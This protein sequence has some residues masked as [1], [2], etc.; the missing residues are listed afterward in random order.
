MLFLTV[1]QTG[2][3]HCLGYLSYSHSLVP[4]WKHAAGIR[5]SPKSTWYHK[6][7]L[8]LDEELGYTGRKPHLQ[9]KGTERCPLLPGRG[10]CSHWGTQTLTSCTER[11]LCITQYPTKITV[12][13]TQ[14]LPRRRVQLADPARRAGGIFPAMRNFSPCPKNR[15]QRC[16]SG[17]W[18]KH[19]VRRS[20]I[21]LVTKCLQG[22]FICEVLQN[23]RTGEGG[24]PHPVQ[25]PSSSRVI[26]QHILQDCIQAVLEYLHIFNS[27][28][29]LWRKCLADQT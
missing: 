20:A 13:S 5:I 26:L 6:V 18:D 3:S 2:I 9:N 21:S 27:N 11:S 25:P 7:P 8:S 29:F 17:I 1:Y 12:W 19:L 14:K 10:H 4:A 23:H 15:L 22:F 24:E 16:G 28:L